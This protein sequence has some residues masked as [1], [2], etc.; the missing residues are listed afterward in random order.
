MSG[1]TWEISSKCNL[2]CKHCIVEDVK[3]KK[4]LTI[5]QNKKIVDALID[6]GVNNISFP[7]K[8]P[9]LYEDFFEL[10]K[11]CD[12]SG[13][14][15]SIVTNGT[16]LNNDNLQKLYD[17]KVGMISISL[18]GATKNTN[19]FIR[20]KGTFKKVTE[21]LNLLKNMNRE[22][23]HKVLVAVQFNLTTLNIHELE[24]I[25]NLA[26]KYAIYQI[27]IGNIEI[28]G[29][30]RN[31]LD[32]V[33]SNKTHLRKYMSYLV[34]EY[35]KLADKKFLLNFKHAGIYEIIYNNTV[36]DENIFNFTPRCTVYN[37]IPQIMPNGDLVL[38]TLLADDNI[39]SEEVIMVGNILKDSINAPYKIMDNNYFNDYKDN[40]TCIKCLHRPECKLCL[41]FS[42][43]DEKLKEVLDD[44]S[45][46]MN[47]LDN[48]VNDVMEGRALFKL[49]ESIIVTKMGNEFMFSRVYKEGIEKKIEIEN[50]DNE[51]LNRLIMFDYVEDYVNREHIKT[52]MYNDLLSVTYKR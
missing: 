51:L 13:I 39:L 29:A 28:K 42:K 46:F 37:G 2:R 27:S 10:L 35:S 17:Y 40:E 7:A 47:K 38:C 21:V 33:I 3:Y 43:N 15:T 45:Y 44:C 19:D 36:F 9:F 25:F 50:I 24:E 18:E 11:Y 14:H 26:E 8:E 22:N 23:K 20:G 4:E 16:L 48:M 32:I 49:K 12:L 52:L 34:N 41:V 1:I 5:E 30:A 31:N 6:R